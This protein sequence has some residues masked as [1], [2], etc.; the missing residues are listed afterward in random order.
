LPTHFTGSE[1]ERERLLVALPG[2]RLAVGSASSR[3]PGRRTNRQRQ[4]EFPRSS[5]S[6]NS[7]KLL[8]RT[9][10]PFTDWIHNS[11][12]HSPS[13][14]PLSSR[15]TKG[16]R[17]FC[18]NTD[19][20]RGTFHGSWESCPAPHSSQGSAPS[21]PTSHLPEL[22]QGNVASTEPHSGSTGGSNTGLVLGVPGLSSM[23][24]D[25][26]CGPSDGLGHVSSS[27]Q[28]VLAGVSKSSFAFGTQIAN[29]QLRQVVQAK[30]KL[31]ER[32]IKLGI[33]NWETN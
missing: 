7:S 20:G 24:W 28:F 30:F 19:S 29:E 3:S 21:R 2:L 13:L 15:G 14:R 32:L 6:C 33:T 9:S 10:G 18:E 16:P 23:R 27:P 25:P 4:Q 22:Q 12:V 31:L 26:T 11:R 8:P 5:N 17:P 1:G